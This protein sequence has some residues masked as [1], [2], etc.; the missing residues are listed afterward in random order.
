LENLRSVYALGA[1]DENNFTMENPSSRFT[2]LARMRAR[3]MEKVFVVDAAAALRDLK[4]FYS[5]YS[6][7]KKYPDDE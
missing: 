1:E 3:C 5:H 6:R 7:S 2:F 4:F